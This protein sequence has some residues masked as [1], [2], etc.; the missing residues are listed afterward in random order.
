MSSQQVKNRGDKFSNDCIDTKI[1]LEEVNP[2]NPFQATKQ[3]ICGYDHLAILEQNC[4][5]LDM[6]YLMLKQELPSKMESQ[7]LNQVALML[8]NLGPRHPATRSAVITAT[9]S[10]ETQH[11]LPISLGILGGEHDGCGN[12]EEAVKALKK[13]VR[14]APS[15]DNAKDLACRLPTVEAIYGSGD[16]SANTFI[17]YFSDKFSSNKYFDWLLKLQQNIYPTE[18]ITKATIAAAAFSELGIH[19]KH[20]SMLYQFL[21]IPGLLAHAAEYVNKPVTALPFESDDD[22]HIETE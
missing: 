22:Y 13:L 10:T 5:Y 20:C 16:S 18:G 2:D 6:A 4:N 9:G 19:P 21:S 3:W 8:M 12:I 11:I 17:H 1:T 14:V 15:S 7:L